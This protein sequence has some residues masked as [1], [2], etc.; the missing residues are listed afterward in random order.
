VRAQAGFTLIEVMVVM[1]IIGL[2]VGAV[3]LS[4]PARPNPLSEQ[5]KAMASQ[6]R[7][8]AQSSMVDRA[9]KGVRL[10]KTGYQVMSYQDGEWLVVRDFEYG[11]EPIP[12]IILM[13]NGAKIN[14]ETAR[15]IEGP[16]V[17]FDATGLATP[18]T[19]SIEDGETL[20]TINSSAAGDITYEI[21][22]SQ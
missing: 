11:V 17:S 8:L 9:S 19:L 13:R 21:Q 6:F 5:G 12:S 4:L 22:E 10:T 2:M 18:F 1:L 7:A 14:L 16:M 15:K 20:V 3:A